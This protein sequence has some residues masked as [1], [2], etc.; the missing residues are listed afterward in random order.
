MH[1]EQPVVSRSVKGFVTPTEWSELQ[2]DDLITVFEKHTTTKFGK[3]GIDRMFS[4]DINKSVMQNRQVVVKELVTN[5]NLFADIQKNLREIEKGTEALL[6]CSSGNPRTIDS[7]YYKFPYHPLL[8][9]VFPIDKLLNNS[10]SAM[11]ISVWSTIYGYLTAATLPFWDKLYSHGKDYN[12]YRK[13]T[14]VESFTLESQKKMRQDLEQAGFGDDLSDEECVKHWLALNKKSSWNYFKSGS[15][16]DRYH[17]VKCHLRSDG[18]TSKI[19]AGM[20]TF[21]YTFMSDLG[22]LGLSAMI[23]STT[24]QLWFD[25]RTLQK[26]MVAIASVMR[27]L[28][29]MIDC[30]NIIG[31]KN[32]YI[33]SEQVRFLLSKN[34]WSTSLHNLVDLLKTSTFD[35]ADS[36]IHC[37]GKILRAYRLLKEAKEEVNTLIEAIAEF[38]ACNAF[39]KFYKIQRGKN[40]QFS[41]VQFIE[42]DKP[43]VMIKDIWTPLVGPENA[44]TNDV[45]LG[46][47]GNPIRA[48]IT[49]PNGYGKSTY[50][51]AIGH[52]VFIAHVCGIAPGSMACMTFFDRVRTSL[53]PQEN[54]L[55]GV[56]T[57]M[58]QKMRI[59]ELFESMKQSAPDKKMFMIFDEPF[60]GTTDDQIIDR[61]YE[62]GLDVGQLP[63]V[64]VCIATHVGKPNQLTRNG[65]FANYQVTIKGE[66]FICTLK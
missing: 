38:D 58:A 54:L 55:A 64:C 41:F 32:S 16:G 14:L 37:R 3:L 48:M 40:G 24:W 19:A 46:V 56:S 20:S 42:S 5:E 52:A 60:N 59:D 27:S 21:G 10:S 13:E 23:L 47:K 31:K 11:E 30:I 57:F 39:A 6:S 8:A 45:L 63:Y 53:H 62:L 50:L 51:K 29:N 26:E 35:T 43:Q 9:L 34:E 65:A 66:D 12:I 36:S 1:A 25:L 7:F 15:A 33:P 2:L 17:I 44:V 22:K 18:I 61:I 28:D 4:S 49:G